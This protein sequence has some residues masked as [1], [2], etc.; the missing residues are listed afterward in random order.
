MLQIKDLRKEIQNILNASV[1]IK[2]MLL[3]LKMNN[4]YLRQ[5]G[6][7]INVFKV[8]NKNLIEQVWK[9]MRINML[10]EEIKPRLIEVGINEKLLNRQINELIL[11]VGSG[12]GQKNNYPIEG[13]ANEGFVEIEVFKIK[14]K[15]KN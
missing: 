3:D 15:N 14:E 9:S 5:K 6:G 13:S 10:V 4:I 7:N 1:G 11:R 2:Q 8:I 12:Q